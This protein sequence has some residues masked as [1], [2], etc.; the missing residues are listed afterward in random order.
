MI[1]ETVIEANLDQPVS[2]TQSGGRDGVHSAHMEPLL[3]ELQYMQRTYPGL[4]W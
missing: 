4:K 3:Q 1:A 2:I